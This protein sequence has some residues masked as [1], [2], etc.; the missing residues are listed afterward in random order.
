MKNESCMCVHVHLFF[1][2]RLVGSRGPRRSL[3]R[4][5][6]C[7]WQRASL[8][9]PSRSPSA[10]RTPWTRTWPRRHWTPSLRPWRCSA[11]RPRTSSTTRPPHL[12]PPAPRSL[13]P[14]PPRSS[15]RR[16]MARC[17][18]A[19]I[20]SLPPCPPPPQSPSPQRPPP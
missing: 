5:L 11:T 18:L 1:H 15:T 2:R 12:G 4:P 7:H 16:A 13:L 10:C 8:L 3:R 19:R 20:T 14:R 17:R 6:L 9:H